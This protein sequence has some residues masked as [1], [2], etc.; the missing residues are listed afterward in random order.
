[1]ASSTPPP[2]LPDR[3]RLWPDADSAA[4]GSGGAATVWRVQDQALGV[5]VALKVLK[6]TNAGFLDRLEREAVLASRVVHPN[7]VGIH[8]VGRTPEGR[9]YLAFALA[10]DGT[11]LD[12]ATRPPPWP[13]LK[14]LIIQL[15]EA[16][17]ALHARGILHLDV[18]LSNLLLHRKGPRERELWLA[19]LGVARALW[20]EDDDDKSVVGTVSYM[21]SERLTG[22]HHLWCPA[23]DLFAVGAVVYRL[24]TGRLPYPARV[25]QEA[26]SQRQRPP[27]TIRARAGLVLPPGI[28]EVVLPMLA[29]DRR[30]RFDHAADVIRA[31]EALPPVPEVPVVPELLGRSRLV[32]W[33]ELYERAEALG[34]PGGRQPR[35]PELG[36]PPWFRPPPAP[37]PPA[38]SRVR[39]RR[40]VPQAPSLLIHR[41]IELVGRDP[42]LELMWRAARTAMRKRRPVLLELTGPP[43]SG[44]TRLVQ[45]FTRA[46]EEGGLGEGLRMEYDV[47]GGA[48]PG[49]RGCWR[50]VMP[51]GSRPEYF[52]HEIAST[53]ARDR[54]ARLEA[55]SGDARQLSAFLAPRPGAPP[56]RRA[57]L[58]S[59]LV[60][61]LERRAWRGLSWL[62]LED[63]DQA[64]EN[65]DCWAVIDEVL[66]CGA[67]VLVL[68]TTRGDRITPSLME[69][70]AR[71]HRAVRTI[72]LE[73]LPAR[74]ADTLVQAHLPLT[75]ELAARLSRHAG[76][77]PKA[78]KD[79]LAHW[80]Q[81]GALEERAAEGA[82]RV[83]ALRADAP[84]LPADQRASAEARLA[85]VALEPE[86]L[87][88]LRALV[89]AG[90][91]APERVVARVVPGGVDRLLISGL[92]D[93]RQ[94][95]L[96]LQ[97]PEL[98]EVVTAQPV[99]PD[100][101]QALHAA[102]AAAWAEEPESPEV[103]RRVGHHRAEA[104][105]TVE[106]LEPLDRALRVLAPVL[107]VPELDELAH[108]T[109]RAARAAA[110]VPALRTGAQQAWLE[111]ALCLADS[112]WR[113]GDAEGAA[114]LDTAI[115]TATLAP[116]DALRAL[117]ARVRRA[118]R[119]LGRAWDE[120]AGGRSLLRA[121]SA[122]RRAEYH[123]TLAL[124]RARRLDTEGALADLLDALS[125]RPEPRTECRARLLR[126]RLLAG[127][128]PMIA[129]NEAMRVV[130][131]ARDHG[132][133][134]FELLAWGLAGEDMVFLG[135]ADEAIERQRSGVARLLAHGE[136]RAAAEARI[137]LGT[138]LRAAGRDRL[139]V[140]TWRAA[141]DGNLP[142]EGTAALGARA[143]LALLAG[144][145]ADGD[146]LLRL[147]PAR[148]SAD[149]A[150]RVAWALLG[151]L[152]ALLEPD[153]EL[154]VL[155][156]AAE[157]RAAVDLGASGVFLVRALVLCLEDTGETAHAAC[158]A[159]LSAAL[160]E[161]CHRRGLESAAVDSLVERFKR[162][163][164]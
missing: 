95:A 31:L 22:Q 131:M 81:T 20:G 86:P 7:V 92:V 42:E 33:P 98:A 154:P 10:S 49:L 21:A 125:C 52:V 50:R 96:V 156:T 23:T 41:E 2:V 163:W 91:G 88:A 72:D 141:M 83:W 150:H 144:L 8:D 64:G 85:A 58:R 36:V 30:A 76:G 27:S 80:V 24:L 87:Q 13:E 60:E 18:K 53:F 106:S 152:G 84:P 46:V 115:A 12:L 114:K 126:A 123:A 127:S 129:W 135:R 108:R 147:V 26:M 145:A 161:E 43:G 130:E 28:E 146:A 158:A 25:P 120:L 128:D 148:P 45:E 38:L 29:F 140:Q 97:P 5:L 162:A 109:L 4:L 48:D 124:L 132:L 78:I 151:P 55:C 104:G 71:H 133:L 16:L 107:P 90:S 34:N 101:V 153:E 63:V 110:L 105:H 3:Y 100:A 69:L 138:T 32:S 70:R 9:G 68:V 121:V 77:N 164:V 94:G 15:L 14:R 54:G 142:G 44:R 117:C 61:H 103:W 57:P 1:M 19:D 35:P 134:R 113:R 82:G 17:G 66:A 116:D 157:A 51:P 99:A 111:A 136:G 67:P 75:P 59:M 40:R 137:H 62:W 143:Q 155:P 102:L 74:V 149:P 47:R 39:P 37:V 73:A 79:L 119:D 122:P 118:D 93:L 65:D 160:A 139:A 89:L 6:S 11:M 112:R 56:P 159:A